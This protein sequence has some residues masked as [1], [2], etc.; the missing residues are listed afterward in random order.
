MAAKKI[1]PAKGPYSAAVKA[2]GFIF[3]AGQIPI[4]PETGQ[5]IEGDIAAQTHQVIR[6]LE[7][8]LDAWGAGLENV[9]RVGIFLKRMSDFAA[10][11]EVYAGYFGQAK[12]ARSTVAVAELP[13]GAEVEMDVV[14]V[15][16]QSQ[17][18][19]ARL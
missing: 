8:V 5:L 1:P 6:N 19:I 18:E 14:A 15:D 16:P 3:T 10:V 17:I 4:D 7:A 12:P 9:V 13:L 2:N 11:N